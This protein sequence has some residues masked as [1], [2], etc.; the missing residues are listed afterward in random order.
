MGTII[1]RKITGP[2]VI[3]HAPTDDAEGVVV[4]ATVIE[5]GIVDFDMPFTL[6]T[7]DGDLV[8]VS[9]PWNCRIHRLDGD[10]FEAGF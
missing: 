9:S 7:D 2:R 1:E 3:V 4:K 6:R 10:V 5:G 8:R